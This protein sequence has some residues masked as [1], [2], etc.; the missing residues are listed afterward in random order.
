MRDRPDHDADPL[1]DVLAVLRVRSGASLRMAA[2]GPWAL[3]FPAYSYLKFI[4]QRSGVLYV[5]VD[6]DAAPYRLAPG[7]CLLM[8]S[9]RPYVAST[10]PALPATDGI[11]HV[12][13]L[14][15]SGGAISWG[16]PG[17]LE[18]IAGRFEFDA[19]QRDL[20]EQVVPP[21]LLVPAA[22]R[23][24]PA[25]HTLLALYRDEA[26]ACAPGQHALTGALARIAL[27]QALRSQDPAPQGWLAALADPKIGAA[28]RLLHGAPARRWTVADLA[29]QVAM[30]RSALALRFRQL[31]GS[32]PLHYL[33]QWR[34]RLA[35]QALLEEGLPVATLAYRLGY[36][37]E[38]A[39]S[40]AFRR[41]TGCA[42]G[43]FRS[44]RPEGR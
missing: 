16:G 27:V 30:S 21:E 35:R 13:A 43:Q 38:S 37:S 5:H 31:V 26:H 19:C 10:D 22:S 32:T 39:F 20:L 40:A 15:C 34:M 2:G 1:S 42:P 36:A 28:L 25:L 12:A 7:D 6:G 24:A 33:Q 23:A 8:R 18:I 3:R 11:A 4:A 9:G 29:G 14:P 44:M 41:S 17:G